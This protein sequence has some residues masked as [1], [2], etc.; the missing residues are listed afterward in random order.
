[1]LFCEIYRDVTDISDNSYLGVQTAFRMV[2]VAGIYMA[3]GL[4]RWTSGTKMLAG[5][6]MQ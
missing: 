2:M 6:I 5:I 3:I 1:M 4:G